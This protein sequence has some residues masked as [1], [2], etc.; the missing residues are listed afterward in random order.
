M[1]T[2]KQEGPRDNVAGSIETDLS[3]RKKRGK[4]CTAASGKATGSKRVAET[5]K[6][7]HTGHAS[8]LKTP[9]I[10]ED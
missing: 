1:V 3:T 10:L 8:D 5:G 9:G 2:Q 4:R 6:M 7:K